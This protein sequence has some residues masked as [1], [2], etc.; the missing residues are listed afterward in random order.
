MNP[1][2]I[3]S[4][5]RSAVRLAAHAEQSNGMS[6]GKWFGTMGGVALLLGGG[7]LLVAQRN[8]EQNSHIRNIFKHE[9][10]VSGAKPHL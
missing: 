4:F 1:T 8:N 2:L 5:H 3:R 7:A 10:G 6:A 9:R